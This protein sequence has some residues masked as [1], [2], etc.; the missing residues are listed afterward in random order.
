MHILFFDT[1]TTGLPKNWRA[2]MTDLDNW[3]RI[4]QLA[5][6]RTDEEGNVLNSEKHL[7][8]PDGWTVP[9]EKFWVE[10]GY[11]TEKCEDEGKSLAGIIDRFLCD[12]IHPDTAVLASHN[13]AFDRNVLGA[14][15]IR[16]DF[17]LTKS[18]NRMCTKEIG[19]NLCQ[20]PSPGRFGFKWP[21]LS[22]LHQFLFNKGFEGAHD[23]MADVIALKDYFFE[24]VRTG[25]ICLPEINTTEA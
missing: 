15:M 6:M 22:E 8:K 3:P 16:Y 14:E 9:K 4:I 10:N 12:V 2:P 24:M 19:T 7:V 11:S 13:M 18:L 20:L 25:V 17:K 5:W 1:E 21:T 23:A